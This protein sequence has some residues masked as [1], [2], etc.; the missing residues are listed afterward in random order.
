VPWRGYLFFDVAGR[1]IQ[2]KDD[3]EINRTPPAVG[4][5]WPKNEFGDVISA[6]AKGDFIYAIASNSTHYALICYDGAYWNHLHLLGS[7]TDYAWTGGLSYSVENAK[8]FLGMEE[9]DGTQYVYHIPFK[10]NTEHPYPL[11]TAGDSG[12]VYSSIAN[13]GWPWIPKSYRSAKVR[14]TGCDTNNYIL[15]EYA[16][17][18]DIALGSFTPLTGTSSTSRVTTSPVQEIDFADNVTG[19]QIAFKWT[20][21]LTGTTATPAMEEFILAYILRPPTVRARQITIQVG[22][23]VETMGGREQSYYRTQEEFLWTCR[24]SIAPITYT[25]MDG[26]DYTVYLNGIR[27]IGAE[28]DKATARLLKRVQL[29][30]IEVKT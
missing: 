24:D 4:I 3:L 21:H 26:N 28:I 23:E 5:T 11:F 25:D 16:V 17:D 1:Y 8:M 15:V 30:L 22:G 14:S 12:I 2:Y 29:S 13:S 19:N 10:T 9:D 6:I 18:E 20:L 7:L 27:I